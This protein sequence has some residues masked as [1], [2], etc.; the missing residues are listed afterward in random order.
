[1]SLEERRPPL[2]PGE[3]APGFILSR[4][5][6]E[7]AVSLADYQE[8]S[9]LFLALFRGLSCAFCRRAMAQLQVTGDRLRALGFETLG[10]V[11]TTPTN[12]R[13]YLRYH[14][15]R[16]ALAA[17]PDLST[18]RAYGL[19]KVQLTWE[20][21]QSTRVNPTGELPEPLPVWET[22]KAL[23][24]LDGFRPT[25]TDRED[26]QR[27]WS[28]SAGEFLIDR[29]GTVRWTFV[30]YTTGDLAGIGRFPT[31]EEILTAARAL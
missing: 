13:L 2:E 18:H 24:R 19:P 4:A 15:A 27:T 5:D 11:A 20:A 30:E 23:T 28:Q 29:G 26:T 25:A 3:R 14:P 22:A 17:D 6:R 7:G 1:M 9:P 16:L 21:V 12:A 10:V 31:D 8:R